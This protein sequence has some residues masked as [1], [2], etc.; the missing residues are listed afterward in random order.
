MG[1]SAESSTG[2]ACLNGISNLRTVP[3]VLTISRLTRW[4]IGYYNDTAHAA[5]QSATDG[6]AAGGGLGEYYCEADTRAPTWLLVGDTAAVAARTGLHG[7]AV[8]GGVVDTAVAAAWLDDGVAPNGVRGRAFSTGGVH[9]FDL[10]FAVPK[11]VSLVRALTDRVAEKVLATAHEKAIAEAMAYLHAHA[12]YTWVH[13]PVTG[14]KDLQRLPGLVAM[15]YQHET[16][17]CGDPHLHTHVIVPNRQP[18]ADGALVALDSKSLR[19]RG[20]ALGGSGARGHGDR[21]VAVAG[22]TPVR[23]GGCGQDALAAR[24]ARRGRAR[25]QGGDRRGANR[26]GGRSGLA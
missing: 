11:S 17:R 25:R 22:A 24:A 4:S 10:T 2:A 26:Q 20:G 19:R 21:D 14:M 3:T 18:R 12:G 15:A 1:D 23:A 9:G 7:A 16:S 5:R 8:A 6:A 13:S